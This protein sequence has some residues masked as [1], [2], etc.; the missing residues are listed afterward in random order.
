MQQ[1]MSVSEIKIGK[2][3]RADLGDLDALAVDINEIG[4]LQPVVV[5]RERV[6]IA[7][8]R[9][10]EAWKRSKHAKRP[11]PVHVVDLAAIAR[12]EWSENVQ[13]KSFTPSEA[14]ALARLVEPILRAEG[15]RRQGH[16]TTAPGKANEAERSKATH[17]TRDLM[18][19]HCGFSTKTLQ[20]AITVVNAGERDQR[21]FGDIVKQ[22][23]ESGNVDAAYRVIVAP[24]TR[25]MLTKDT[26]F[27]TTRIGDVPLGDF[28][29]PEIRWLI[30]FFA[31]LGA[32]IGQPA[33]DA[34][35]ASEIFKP[36][37]VRCAIKNGD[38]MRGLTKE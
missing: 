11:I 33:S 26:I 2:R 27:T 22:M 14:V 17:S 19:K 36:D 15:R 18:A 7:G 30:G 6:L 31:E 8:E 9:R 5:S 12:G 29:A 1:V 4:L 37:E 3:A 38:R 20:K 23:D 32:R 24:S 28:T 16:G 35:N 13:R 10:I 34:I 25:R 21:R